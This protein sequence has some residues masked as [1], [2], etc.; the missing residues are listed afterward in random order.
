MGHILYFIFCITYPI[1]L[2]FLF[3][4][5]QSAGCLAIRNLIART[6]EFC[7][8]FLEQG[9]EAVLRQAQ[10]RYPQCNDAAKA[11]LRDLG[12]SVELKELWKGEGK[13]IAR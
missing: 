5:L 7:P 10:S 3:I 4:L 11:G 8:A 13:G 9:A 1:L 2:L 6:R 12:C